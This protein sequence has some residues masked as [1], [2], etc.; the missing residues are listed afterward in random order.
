MEENKCNTCQEYLQY[1]SDTIE[2]LSKP[3]SPYFSSYYNNVI[4]IIFGITLAF[5]FDDIFS[6]IKTINNNFILVNYI[7]IILCIAIIWNTYTR[8]TQYSFFILDKN[9]TFIPIIISS[10]IYIML[11]FKDNIAYF[12]ISLSYLNLMASFAF[13]HAITRLEKKGVLDMY[14]YHYVEKHPKIGSC[15]WKVVLNYHKNFFYLYA[16]TFF[17]LLAIGIILLLFNKVNIQDTYIIYL[18][19]FPVLSMSFL[20]EI[21]KDFKKMKCLSHYL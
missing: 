17:V 2:F 18:F 3:V 13:L 5:V 11:F 10:I 19:I 4:S 1:N 14:T 7:I 21:N 16:Q 15:L 9:D 12:I 6:N 8:L 20:Y